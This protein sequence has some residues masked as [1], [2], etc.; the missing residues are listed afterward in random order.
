MTRFS[1]WRSSRG[2]TGR[3]VAEVEAQAVGGDEAAGLLD[4]GAERLA[5]GGVEE[6]RA[7][8]GGAW[9]PRGASA[10]TS[11]RTIMPALEAAVGDA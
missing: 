10:S 11:A 4:V 5:Q 6:V 8:C 7:A 2:P 9:R 1:M 3:V